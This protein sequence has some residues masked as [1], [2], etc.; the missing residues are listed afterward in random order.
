MTGRPNVL[1]VMT[2][3]QRWDALAHAGTFPV[4]TPNLD[5]LADDG[6]WFRRTYVQ[7]PLCVPSRASLLTGRYVHQHGCQDNDHSLWPEAPS[8]V[9]S[10][11]DEGYRTANVGKLHFTWFHDVELLAADPILRRMGFDE[12]LETTGKMSRGN[13]RASPYTEHLRSKGL[14]EGYLDDLLTRVEDGPYEARPSILDEEDHIDGWV[15]RGAADWLSAVETEPFFCWVGPP[16]PHDPFDPP[17][18]YASLYD[19]ADMPLGPLDYQ[20]P[21]GPSVASKDVP[22][23]T[24]EQIQRMRAMYLANVT[25]IDAW[26]GRLMQVL[27]DRD[28]LSDTWV[29]FCSDHGEMLGDHKLVGKAQFF[30]PA[31]RVPLIVRPPDGSGYARGMVRDSLVELIDVSATILDIAGTSLDG[32]QGR[33]LLP[34][35]REESPDRHRDVV[36]SQVE[37]RQMIS[38]GRHKV[39]IQDGLVLHAFDTVTDPGEVADAVGSGAAWIHDLADRADRAFATGPALGVPWPHL[40]PYQHWGRNVLKELTVRR[41]ASD[42]PVRDTAAETAPDPGARHALPH[43]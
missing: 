26:V 15:M 16:G 27:R 38:D 34:L 2:D 12:P 35:L 24:P 29:I 43:Q 23:A 41:G 6:V 3:Q 42:A 39:E 19:P 32:H 5:R 7:S 28:L 40:T 21:V 37:D 4:Q 25:Y 18:P 31:V 20:Y 30:D 22:D 11:Q 33:S 1:L 9:R 17:E 13:V 14:L 8:F 10:L 36:L